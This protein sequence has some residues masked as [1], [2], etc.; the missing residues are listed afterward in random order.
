MKM[1]KIFSYGLPFLLLTVFV[2]VM[3][4]GNYLKQP[5]GVTDNVPQYMTRL[6]ES[7]I[8]QDWE[9]AEANLKKLNTAWQQV[10]PR[11]QYSV[12]RN[13]MNEID[14]NLARL[15]GF[16][17]AKDQAGALAELSEAEEQWNQLGN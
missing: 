9:G 8:K 10:I 17:A 3:L 2:L 11:I 5:R 1:R 14:I 15:K 13:E 4:S 6:Q 16:I 7:I 12:E